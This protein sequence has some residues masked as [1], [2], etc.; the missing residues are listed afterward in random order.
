MWKKD[1]VAGPMQAAAPETPPGRD[2]PVAPRIL[3]EATIGP[4]I[5]IRGEVSGDEDRWTAPCSSSS[6]R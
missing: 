3:G 1:E 4:S 2:R 5:A 6:T